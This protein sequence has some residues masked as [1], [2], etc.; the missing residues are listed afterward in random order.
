IRLLFSLLLL[1]GPQATAAPKAPDY[2]VGPQDR[3]VITVFG[4]PTLTN[5]GVDID[6]EGVFEF[7]HIGRVKAGGM[8]V[9]QIE[10]EVTR[11]LSPP[12]GYFRSPQVTVTIERYRP[13]VVWVQ[14]QVRSPGAVQMQGS[15]SV[16]EA[17]A[18][19]GSQLADAGPYVEIYRHEAGAPVTGPAN[20]AQA[21]TVK[22]PE[23]VSMADIAS[24]RAQQVLLKPNYTVNVPKAQ[25]AYILGF[26]R[27]PGPI[28]LDSEID[29][30][31]ALVPAGG[32]PERGAKG[33][34]TLERTEDGGRRKRSEERRGGEGG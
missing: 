15:M 13:Q 30:R 6:S 24:G 18:K 27:A 19:A 16:M 21:K 8:T 12:Q 11:L 31:K 28:V 20:P 4:E 26:V 10:Q 2:V 29:L 33:G 3:L 9:R 17:I 1:L 7:P 22:P 14:G 23:R 32:V 5:V 34:I 25:L